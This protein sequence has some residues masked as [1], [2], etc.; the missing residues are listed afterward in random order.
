MNAVIFLRMF[1]EVGEVIPAAILPY[2]WK[3]FVSGLR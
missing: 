2:I 1:I 3:R